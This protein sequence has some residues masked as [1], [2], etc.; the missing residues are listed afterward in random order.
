MFEGIGDGHDRM[1][2]AS[3]VPVAVFPGLHTLLEDLFESLSIRRFFFPGWRDVGIPLAAFLLTSLHH[4]PILLQAQG[5]GPAA[6]PA[7]LTG[8]VTRSA[9]R[10]N[11]GIH[12]FPT[13]PAINSFF[14]A[15]RTRRSGWC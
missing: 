10:P 8:P 6:R 14:P 5:E 11:S 15:V 9:R 13:V 4:S 1:P 2:Q 12:H 3:G 7:V